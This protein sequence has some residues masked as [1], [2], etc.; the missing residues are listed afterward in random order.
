[1]QRVVPLAAWIAVAAVALQTFAHLGTVAFDADAAALNA[2]EEHNAFA[3]AS[4]M[5]TF[6]AGFFLFV[7]AAAA[8]ALDRVTLALV[9]ALL[10]FSLDDAISFHERLAE[11]SIAVLGADVSLQR[12]AWPLVYLPALAFVFIMLWRM[13]ERST[14]IKVGLGLLA[15]ALVAEVTSALYV[16]EGDDESWAAAFEV[17]VEE[18]A[19]L[20]GWVLVAGA[21]AT[22]AFELAGRRA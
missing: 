16:S 7:P 17:V 11:K 13:A 14:A 6:A 22:R 4:S 9:G 21:L 12:I 2:D 3:W 1:M 19:E 8:G 5:A 20:G 10:F 18:G 15:A